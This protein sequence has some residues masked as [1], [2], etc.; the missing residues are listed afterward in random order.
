MRGRLAHTFQTVRAYTLGQLEHRFASQLPASLFPKAANK[1]NS[2]N[3]IYTRP[4]TFWSMLWQGLNP[5]ASGRQVVRQIQALFQLQGG[6]RPSQRDGAYC[7]AK[8]R[9]PLKDFPKALQA[10]AQSADRLAPA[11]TLLQGRSIKLADGSTFTAPDTRK[12]RRC[13][14][15][16]QTPQPNFPMLRVMV[17]F[18]LVSGAVLS[19]VT[20][21]LRTAE[22]PMLYQMFPLLVP[23]DILVADRGFGNF[24]L[25]A[26]LGH[27]KPGVDFIGRSARRVDGRRRLKRLGAQDWLVA[28]KKGAN[29]SLWLPAHVWALLPNEITVRIVR[30]SCSVKGF[31]VRRVTLVTT[32]L[33][34]ERYPAVEILQAYLRRW[35]LE[36][37]LDDLKTTLEMEM[38]RSRSPQMLQKEIYAHLIAH[39]LIRC[40]MAQA[41][42]QYAVPLE[43]ISFKGTLDALRQFTQAMTQAGTKKKRSQLWDRL[44]ETLARDL[45][46]HRPGRREPRAIKRAKNKYPRLS[47]PRHI[48]SDRPKRNVRR[49][50]SRMR[51]LGLK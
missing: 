7:R 6:R 35:R 36:M 16:L 38:L 8:A 42:T 14:P 26:L 22:L 24:V 18:S 20:G 46:P 29:P 25:L 50:V 39:N 9:L 12:N 34:P 31:R 23:T 51:K 33:H 1:A 45:V 30:G 21:D 47:C 10:S 13:Y 5:K 41:A 40:T 49:T 19:V 17:L 28:W 48:F 11:L 3:R 2:R 32:L 37:C 4:R 43:R 27:F 15:P 44:L